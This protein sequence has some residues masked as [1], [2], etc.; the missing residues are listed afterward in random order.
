MHLTDQHLVRV[1][2]MTLVRFR[3]IYLNHMLSIWQE[4]V[5]FMEW[6]MDWIYPRTGMDSMQMESS[7]I[8]PKWQRMSPIERFKLW[9]DMATVENIL[10]NGC[11]EMP[12]CWK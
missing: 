7:C 10:L 11:G 12:N 3:N 8:V 4:S 5:I 6:L 9:V 1:I 2:S